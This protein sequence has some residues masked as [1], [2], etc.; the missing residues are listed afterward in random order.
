MTQDIFA[1]PIRKTPTRSRHTATS[2]QFLERARHYRYAA[3]LT[4]N[5][6][7]INDLLDLAFMFV[8]LARD[9]ARFESQ[10]QKAMLFVGHGETKRAL[11]SFRKLPCAIRIYI[12]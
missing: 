8:H 6:R 1:A 4:D 3:A 5:P 7:A 2:T 12:E 10:K 9:F 11:Y